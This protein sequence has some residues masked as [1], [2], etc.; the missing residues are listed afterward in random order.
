M[1]NTFSLNGCNSGLDVVWLDVKDLHMACNF[2][3]AKRPTA[4]S[5]NRTGE[6]AR[7]MTEEV[8]ELSVSQTIAD[9]ADALMDLIYFALGAFVELGIPPQKIFEF[10][11]DA[12]LAKAWPTGEM[13]C[14]E[15]GKLMKPPSWMQPQPAIRSYIEALSILASEPLHL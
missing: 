12:N 11:H 8:N 2:P 15:D 5:L 1:Q 7:W 3:V 14:G 10:V 4:M 6:W 13:K 9:Q